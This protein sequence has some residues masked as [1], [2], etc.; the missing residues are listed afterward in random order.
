MARKIYCISSF[1]FKTELLAPPTPHT[2]QGRLSDVAWSLTSK[3]SNQ[4]DWGIDVTNRMVS[5]K[6]RTVYV[7]QKPVCRYRSLIWLNDNSHRSWK[8][9]KRLWQT[10]FV[11]TTS[12]VTAT[13]HG[14]TSVV[15]DCQ[16]V[17]L[18]ADGNREM[19]NHKLRISL[20]RDLL[21]W[22][23]I[24]SWNV[25]ARYVRSREPPTANMTF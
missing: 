9:V 2:I 10:A 4:C 23:R 19:V 22:T 3:T 13:V 6:P 21:W 17:G 16:L 18:S 8:M 12:L 5:G 1:C 7:S 24:E 25:T 14:T 15:A 20:W 11:P